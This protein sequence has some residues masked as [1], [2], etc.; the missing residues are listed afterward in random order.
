MKKKFRIIIPTIILT[1]LFAFAS[2]DDPIISK[3]YLDK[4][5]EAIRIE[6]NNKINGIGS[7]TTSNQTQPSST[8]SSFKPLQIE[9]GKTVV[10]SEG[11]EIIHRSGKAVVIDPTGNGIPD[12]TSGDNLRNGTDITKNHYLIIPRSDGR[13]I[14][15]TS[16]VWIMLKGNA[17]VLE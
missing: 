9:A 11:S 3:S 1:T 6:F 16:S 13:G 15:T 10:F 5:I 7:N 8:N 14:M 17:N 2:T 12:L 4:Q